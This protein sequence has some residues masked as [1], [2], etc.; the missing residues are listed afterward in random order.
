MLQ[1]CYNIFRWVKKTY[2]FCSR[3]F[4]VADGRSNESRNK[5]DFITGI[6]IWGGNYETQINFTNFMLMHDF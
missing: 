4:S 1:I 6:L 3:R 2:Y 5:P